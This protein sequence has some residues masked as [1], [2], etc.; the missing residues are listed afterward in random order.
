MEGPCRWIPSWGPLHPSSSG[1]WLVRLA[2]ESRSTVVHALM[3]PCAVGGVVGSTSRAASSSGRTRLQLWP[4]RNY[5]SICTSPIPAMLPRT[6][7][8]CQ[9]S[10]SRQCSFAHHSYG[11]GYAITWPR[12]KDQTPRPAWCTVLVFLFSCILVLLYNFTSPPRAKV[13]FGRLTLPLCRRYAGRN[14]DLCPSLACE[15]SGIRSW[16]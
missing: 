16:S 15:A 1:I 14:C 7:G 5:N 4:F 11:S 12:D 2:A 10:A 6:R 13:R 9:F 8:N 3:Q